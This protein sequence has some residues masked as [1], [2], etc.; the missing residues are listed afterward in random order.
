[1]PSTGSGTGAFLELGR[2]AFLELAERNIKIQFLPST[3]SGTSAFLEL[4]R[5]AFLELAERNIKIQ[6]LPS[7]GSVFAFDRLRHRCVP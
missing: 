7:T 2:D 6:F 4:G 5:D 3:G 1:L